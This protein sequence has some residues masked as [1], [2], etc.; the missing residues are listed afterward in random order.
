MLAKVGPRVFPPVLQ[1]HWSDVTGLRLADAPTLPLWM[2]YKKK[3]CVCVCVCVCVSVILLDLQ[4]L[5]GTLP[6]PSFALEMV[7]IASFLLIADLRNTLV[8]Y[9]IC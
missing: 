5:E 7:V 4:M 8:K 3:V 6:D 2:W 9:T 1:S